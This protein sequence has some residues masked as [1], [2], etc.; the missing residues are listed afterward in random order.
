MEKQEKVKKFEEL[1]GS[2]ISSDENII[3]LIDMANRNEEWRSSRE[4]LDVCED[5]SEDYNSEK[6][7]GRN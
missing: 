4:E 6:C 2:A 5:K 7:D 3:D 1:A